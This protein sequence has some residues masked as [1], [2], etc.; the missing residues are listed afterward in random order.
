MKK[1][2]LLILSIIGLAAAQPAEAQTLAHWND[3]DSICFYQNVDAHSRQTLYILPVDFSAIQQS[4]DNFKGFSKS[5][6]KSTHRTVEKFPASIKKHLAKEFDNLN[7]QT[8]ES[9]PAGIAADALVMKVV[10]TNWDYSRAGLQNLNML[11]TG[12]GDMGNPHFMMTV[13]VTDGKGQPVF[14]FWQERV[15]RGK[16][17]FAKETNWVN[18]VNDYF[19]DDMVNALGGLDQ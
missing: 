4:Y 1:V 3:I 17:P 11:V 19:I 18:G 15:S 10:Y 13:T 16:K 6:V 7:I 5:E 9:L 2:L 8:V 12:L 14:T